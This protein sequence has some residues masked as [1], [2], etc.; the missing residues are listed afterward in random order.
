MVVVVIDGEPDQNDY[1]PS[2]SMVS[3]PILSLQ[4]METKGPLEKQENPK[5]LEPPKFIANHDCFKWERK[6]ANN[7]K[8]FNN[9]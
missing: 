7:L 9:Y 2:L 1:D 5:W 6:S 8:L 4:E 3:L